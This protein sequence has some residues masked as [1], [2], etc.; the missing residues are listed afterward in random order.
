MQSTVNPD[1]ARAM[2]EWHPM[3]LRRKVWAEQVM[4]ALAWL[5]WLRA[6]LQT[7]GAP[8]RERDD[9]PWYRLERSTADAVA[10]ALTSW[11]TMRDLWAEALFTQMYA[12]P[13]PL[14]LLPADGAV[15]PANSDGRKGDSECK[16]ST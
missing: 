5:P 9:N 15:T 2:R 3:R 14:D 7:L 13:S 4:P 12:T 8:D 1:F 16:P 11:R 6:S 10:G